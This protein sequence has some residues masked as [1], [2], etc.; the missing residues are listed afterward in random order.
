[1]DK[2]FSE[3][4]YF[5]ELSKQIES[6]N[7]IKIFKSISD[8]LNKY[9]GQ[10]D[11]LTK[12]L[13]EE[14]IPYDKIEHEITKELNS[15]PGYISNLFYHSRKNFEVE[16]FKIKDIKVDSFY[17][18]KDIKPEK[19]KFLVHFKVDLKIIYGKENQELIK[20]H[21][22]NLNQPTWSLETFDKE[23]KPVF[24]K[25]VMFI[26]EGELK[27][28]KKVISKLKFIDFFIDYYFLKD[29]NGSKQQAI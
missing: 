2:I 3:N 27:I 4:E 19:N 26:F 1:M 9:G 24:D 12:E 14:K 16:Y 7:K 5:M 15:F 22:E 8:F 25:P 13:I 11:F 17:S 20:K 10:Y 21:L 29:N 28:K 6:K 18:Y 23:Y